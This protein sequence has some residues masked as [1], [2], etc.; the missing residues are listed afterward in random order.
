MWGGEFEKCCK[1]M[2]IMEDYKNVHN[3]HSNCVL[4]EEPQKLNPKIKTTPSSQPQPKSASQT[5]HCT[6]L[7]QNSVTSWH[8]YSDR[9]HDF[10]H[11]NKTKKWNRVWGDHLASILIK[12]SRKD[13]LIIMVHLSSMTLCFDLSISIQ[14]KQKGSL[15]FC[16]IRSLLHN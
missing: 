5:M 15:S 3:G 4:W 9:L 14:L 16:L 7:P 11:M 10:S 6:L 8:A 12:W 2:F 13:K 1:N